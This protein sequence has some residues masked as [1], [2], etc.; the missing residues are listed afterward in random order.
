MCSCFLLPPALHATVSFAAARP[1]IVDETITFFRA[2][3]MFKSF[4]PKGPADRV[5]I[6]LTKFV[7]EVCACVC[8]M[9][10]CMWFVYVRAHLRSCLPAV[11][12][13]D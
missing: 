10:S 3:I 13:E 8:G 2:N 12:E 9:G 5:L 6:Y 4:D 1:D 11:P 7:F